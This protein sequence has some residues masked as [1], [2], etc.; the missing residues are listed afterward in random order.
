MVNGNRASDPRELNKGRGSKFQVGSCVRQETPEE[1]RRIYRSK[2]REYKNKDK[3]NRPKTL[4]DKKR[5]NSGIYYAWNYL[6]VCKQIINIRLNY[7]EIF[8]IIAIL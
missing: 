5:T 8:V 7:L 3:D 2:R 6:T 4:N 1:D